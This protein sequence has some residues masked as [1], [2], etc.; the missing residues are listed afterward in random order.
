MAAL[1][2]SASAAAEDGSSVFIPANAANEGE[3][4]SVYGYCSM[5]MAIGNCNFVASMKDGV[6]VNVEGDPA[7]ATNDG[8][9]CPRGKGMIMNLYNPHRIKAP[10]KRTNPEKGV[11]VDPGWVEISWEEA[12]DIAAEKI[13]AVLDDDPRKLVNFFGFA[14]YEAASAA[15]G[16]GVWA[17][18]L[19][20]PNIVSTNG[21]MCDLHYGGLFTFD[22]F[23]TVNYDSLRTEYVVML[24]R[25]LGADYGDS[26][27]G[28][29]SFGQNLR[30]KHTKYVFVAP[31]A[32]MESSRG[33]WIP[34]RQGYDL[35]LVYSWLHCM[36]YEID[37]G[38]DKEFVTNRTNAP[39]LI[40]ADGNYVVND[41]GKPMLWDKKS[42]SAKAW[43][44]PTLGEPALEGK[45]KVNGKSC[46]VAFQLF[47]ESLKDF[48]PEWAEPLTDV[49]AAKI[50]EIVNDLVAHAHFG[51]TIEIEGKKVPFRPACVLI[52]RGD[53]NQEDGTLT[54]I[55]SRVLNIL[56]GNI[57]VPGGLL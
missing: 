35:A 39:Y 31:R 27:G 53:T 11:D 51:E 33:E 12:I 3:K 54:D 28:A 37:N 2:G 50:R 22:S 13:Q 30:T 7:R 8:T 23:P 21:E 18:L 10:M 36:L 46:T 43:D 44:D 17:H 4:E 15:F 26:G 42:D 56:L 14:A 29:R 20:T 24:G 57:G 25:G 34:A 5:C 41:D 52:G 6:V 47:K 9:L 16:L 32:S 1:P 49:P 40:D 48:T 45:H 55:F 19:G 38:F